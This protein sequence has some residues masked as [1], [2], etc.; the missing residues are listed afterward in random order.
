L[1]VLL[2][3]DSVSVRKVLG[4]MLARAGYEVA[5]A[6]DG[7]EAMALLEAG[8]C[9][10]LIT[11]LEMPRRNGYELLAWL[12]R[13]PA[14]A[15]LPALVVTT[16]IG[17]KHRELALQVGAV[18]CLSKPVEEEVLLRTVADLVVRGKRNTS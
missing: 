15:R 7:E 3:D 10:L 11:D 12:R 8:P 18:S 17:E 13:R 6:V 9:D 4:G 5:L 16:R 2:A 1:R 14:T